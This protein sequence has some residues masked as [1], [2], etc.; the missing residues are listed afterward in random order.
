MIVIRGP[1]TTSRI[2]KSAELKAFALR[3]PRFTEPGNDG[4]RVQDDAGYQFAHRFVAAIGPNCS[5]A[6]GDKA[7]EIEHGQA[8]VDLAL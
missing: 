3:A 8:L 7:F 2:V 5:V 4:R 1:Q 6:V